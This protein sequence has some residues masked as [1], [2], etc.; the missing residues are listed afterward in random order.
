M[1]A[2]ARKCPSC[3][4]PVQ[5]GAP[6]CGQCGC[7]LPA[8][9]PGARPRPE[10]CPFCSAPVESE[11]LACRQCGF[12]FDYDWQPEDPEEEIAFAPK[13]LSCRDCGQPNLELSHL[14]CNCNAPI[15]NTVAL[16]PGIEGVW[17][18]G[19]FYRRLVGPID[20]LPRYAR[21]TRRA[22]GG[23]D[24]LAAL[25]MLVGAFFILDSPLGWLMALCAIPMAVLN[26]AF[27]YLVMFGRKPPA[28]DAEE[29]PDKVAPPSVP[30]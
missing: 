25:A 5:L 20:T 2:P 6:F 3:H 8:P 16:M 7:D 30:G 4:A 19:H 22:W 15:S 11:E 24:M 26:G 17:F 10:K 9:E 14:C 27:G 21:L 13:V 12:D 23:L 29:S 18:V 1:E 28:Y